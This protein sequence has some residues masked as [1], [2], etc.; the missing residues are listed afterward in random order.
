MEKWRELIGH[1]EQLMD[2]IWDATAK[3]IE[4]L[5]NKE[6]FLK[7]FMAVCSDTGREAIVD[8]LEVF[9]SEP[10]EY[11]SITLPSFSTIVVQGEFNYGLSVW[12][13]EKQL[14]KVTATALGTY[15]FGLIDQAS[16]EEIALT[17]DAELLPESYEIEGF[18]VAELYNI[19]EYYDDYT[20][21][22]R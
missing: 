4:E 2:M 9:D 5:S 16:G 3:H 8:F 18:E 11:R 17:D 22:G 1:D 10:P 7:S 19:E 21:I 13:G 12:N 6:K 14:G 15:S 20:A